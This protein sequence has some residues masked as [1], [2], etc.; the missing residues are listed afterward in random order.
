MKYKKEQIITQEDIQNFKEAKDTL[1]G[2]L[3]KIEDVKSSHQAIELLEKDALHALLVAV[4]D[5][6]SRGLKVE[7]AKIEM[8]HENLQQRVDKKELLAWRELVEDFDFD[9]AF[10]IMQGWKI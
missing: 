6:L 9:E 2:E 7:D 8:L 4:Q 3:E 5:S 10:L 1:L